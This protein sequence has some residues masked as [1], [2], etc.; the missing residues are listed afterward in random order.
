[1]KRPQVGDRVESLAKFVGIEVGDV[2]TVIEDYG[3]GI[4]VAWHPLP[5]VSLAEIASMYAIDP[6]CP[7][8]DEFGDDELD[9][10]EVIE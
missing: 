7:Q 9:L 6:K 10:L 4:M 2:G 3:A 8:R 1:M 5:Q